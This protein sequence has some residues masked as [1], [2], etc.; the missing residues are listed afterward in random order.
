MPSLNLSAL[1]LPAGTNYPATMQELFN[2][3]AAYMQVLGADGLSGII[4]GTAEPTAADRNKPWYRLNADGIFLGEHYWNGSAWVIRP[5]VLAKG[6]TVNRP[7]DV[8]IGTVYLDTDIGQ[9]LRWAGSQWTTVWGGLGQVIAVSRIVGKIENLEQALTHY[10]GWVEY[11][12]ARCRTLIGVGEVAGLLPRVLGTIY[13][14]DQI[15][16]TDNQLPP[17]VHE[18]PAFNLGD[19]IRFHDQTGNQIP[20]VAATR[21]TAD[22]S[23]TGLDNDPIDITPPSVGVYWLRKEVA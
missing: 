20:E 8:A 16:L 15:I 3:V 17:H 7:Q 2:M 11:T 22:G 6:S 14:D 13:G 18:F 1:T 21:T 5:K 19:G 9:E 10:P 12:A 23:T 4:V